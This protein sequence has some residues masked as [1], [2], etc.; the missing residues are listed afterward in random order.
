MADPQAHDRNLEDEYDE[1]ADSDFEVGGSDPEGLTSSE[2][3]D[4]DAD[5][6]PRRPRKRQKSDNQPGQGDLIVEL[7]SGDEATVREHKKGRRKGRKTDDAVPEQS[8][9]DTEGWRARTRGMRTKEKEERR[10]NKLAS[11]KGSTIDVNKIWEEMNRPGTLLPSCVEGSATDQTVQSD[12][13]AGSPDA[14]AVNK[15]TDKENVPVDDDEETITIKRTYK[16]AG[17]VHVEEKKVLKSSAEARLWLSQQD[18]SKPGS[19]PTDGKAVNR[20]LRKISRFDPN[21]NNPEAFK[22]SW[23]PRTAQEV[24]FKGPKL[25]VVE[26]SKMDWAEHVDTEGLQEELDTHAKAKEGY[27]TRMDFLQQVAERRDAEA[28]VARIKG[29]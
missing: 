22:G 8:G 25:N 29:R 13:I 14:G 5:D 15:D 28:R 7:D 10:K 21:F 4:R 23:T 18:S 11:S 19:P 24:Q 9:D 1:E 16:F 3:D 17:E 26:K 20:P 6:A 27:L 2:D 12:K